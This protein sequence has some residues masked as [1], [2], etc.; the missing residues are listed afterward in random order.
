MPG[1]NIHVIYVICL[2]MLGIHLHFLFPTIDE[3]RVS[4]PQGGQKNK[5]DSIHNLTES[6]NSLNVTIARIETT[7]NVATNDIDQIKN[8]MGET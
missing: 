4:C 3:E 1:P 7:L 2:Q 5:D 8:Q 6:Y